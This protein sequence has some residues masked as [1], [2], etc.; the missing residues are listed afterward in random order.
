MLEVL[1]IAL[2][3]AGFTAT[4]L[5][6]LYGFSTLR[7]RDELHHTQ[8]MELVGSLARSEPSYGPRDAPRRNPRSHRNPTRP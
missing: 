4:V 5:S 7:R 6:L 2:T 3:V 8:I 1:D